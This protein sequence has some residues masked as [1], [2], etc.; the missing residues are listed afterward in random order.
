M[1]ISN[2]DFFTTFIFPFMYEMKGEQE[3][4]P[5]DIAKGLCNDNNDTQ[6]G[7][8][9]EDYKIDSM[10]N[11]NEFCYFHPFVRNA[12][13]NKKRNEGMEYLKREDFKKLKVEYY[14]GKIKE[15]REI[16]T[17]VKSIDMHLFDNQ[18]GLLTITTERRADDDK[19]N[20]YD[21]LKY[22]DIAR[23]VYP[24]FLGDA[25]NKEKEYECDN[26]YSP[27]YTAGLLPLNISLQGSDNEPSITEGYQ[28]IDLVEGAKSG[29]DIL[30]FSHIIKQLLKPF[31][32][33]EKRDMTKGVVYYTPFTD[34]RMF[35][36][37][38][39][40]DNGLSNK[41]KDRCCDGYLYENDDDWYRFIFVDGG[42][43]GIDNINMKK[44]LIQKHTYARWAG[45]GTLFGMSRYSFVLLTSPES[46]NL[47]QH[48][49]SMYY[50]IAL[51][52]LFQRAMLLKF[53]EDVDRITKQFKAKEFKNHVNETGKLHIDF[54]RFIN[55]YWFVEVTPQEHGTEIYKQWMGLLDLQKLYDEVQREIA[56]ISEYVETGIA[57][58]TNR[59]L[60]WLT[61]VGAIAAVLALW[62]TIRG[63]YVF[64]KEF[65]FK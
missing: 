34:D 61:W 28:R 63:F 44:E 65:L 59:I 18:I 25:C 62:P 15:N 55:K 60:L 39:Y 38:Y 50:Q 33:K 52:V 42:S 14:D 27:K 19:T 16:T 9:V 57:S 20:F 5:D 24:P 11:Y 29:K 53:A 12:I 46:S 35:V 45:S 21:L 32:L 4:K 37:S 49:K 51:M 17:D 47:K 48:M 64:M 8:A 1:D 40:S 30:Y 43:A 7:W 22:N 6:K 58:K 13:F 3:F 54:I 41:M 2:N 56:E 23:R 26:T 31:E 10:G 36:V